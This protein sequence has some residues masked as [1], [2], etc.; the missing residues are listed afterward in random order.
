M[1]FA[2]IKDAV[3]RLTSQELA[4]LAELIAQQDRRAWDQEIESDFG[5]GGRLQEMLHVVDADIEAGRAT[6]LP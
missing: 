3:S 6:P 1:S 4:E 2:Q 5:P